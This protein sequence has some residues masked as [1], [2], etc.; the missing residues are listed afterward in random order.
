MGT[1]EPEGNE[2]R[3]AIAA[4][5]VLLDLR[6]V[7]GLMEIADPGAKEVKQAPQVLLVV[8]EQPLKALLMNHDDQT[9]HTSRKRFVL[10]TSRPSMVQREPL[11]PGLRRVTPST[12]TAFEQP[13]SK[14]FR[15]S[16]P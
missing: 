14:A 4:L 13:S 10:Q 6:V 15:E 7:M 8:L 5:Q 9:G 3:P 11:K 2:A 1:V 16:L 12:S